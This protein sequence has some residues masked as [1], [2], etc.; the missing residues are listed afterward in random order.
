MINSKND[1]NICVKIINEVEKNILQNALILNCDKIVVAVSGGPDSMCLLDILD[2]LNSKFEK[3]YDIK[4][5]LVVAHVN[6]MIREESEYEKIYVENICKSKDIPFYYLKKDVKTLSKEL[7]MSEE[8]C[9]RRVRYDFFEEVR[10]KEN[11]NKI[12]VAHNEDDNVET[13]I[14]NIIR[15]SGLKGLTGMNYQVNNLIRPLLSIEK[16]DILEYNNIIKLNPCFD[17]TNNETVYLRNKIR[18]KLIPELKDEYNSN[19]NKNIIRMKKILEEEED[20][21]EKYTEGVVNSSINF[22]NQESIEF[23]F[24]K[25][26]LEH[27]AIKTRAIRKIIEL[28]ISNL[29]GIE[30]VHIMDILELFK[31][32]IRGKKYIIGNKFR[33]EIVSKNVANI[34]KLI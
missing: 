3:E 33:I 18:N 10:N 25:I 24:S 11:A 9:G 32:N 17:K 4:Y 22:K 34:Y 27:N 23:D 28:L 1:N 2:K 29:D 19:I 20:F 16:K 5:S 14:L 7:K 15:G 13:I 21:L 30:N 31:N 26:L 6:H 8:A 12:A